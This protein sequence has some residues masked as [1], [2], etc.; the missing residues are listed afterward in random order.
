MDGEW[1]GDYHEY[2]KELVRID[3]VASESGTAICATKITGDHI[4][5]AGMVTWEV[6]MGSTKG[7]ANCGQHGWCDGDL[8]I[9][10]PDHIA[11]RWSIWKTVE[12]KRAATSSGKIEDLGCFTGGPRLNHGSA[13]LGWKYHSNDEIARCFQDRFLPEL[14]CNGG[15]G[16]FGI[17][18]GGEIFWCFEKDRHRLSE[19]GRH[20]KGDHGN[21]HTGRNHQNIRIPGFSGA[22]NHIGGDCEL[23]IHKVT[24]GELARIF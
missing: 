8:I 16:Y 11:F 23:Q 2:G 5:A 4:V 6:P 15:V 12:Y 13:A 21:H 3:Y 14:Q 17:E 18:C 7:R 22:I 24:L 20:R 10:G 19:G 9:H 1:V